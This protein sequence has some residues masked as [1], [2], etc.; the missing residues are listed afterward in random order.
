MHRLSLLIAVGDA[1]GRLDQAA[2]C[3]RG[4]ELLAFPVADCTDP[5][6]AQDVC[7]SIARAID[8]YVARGATERTD[9]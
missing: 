1:C 9:T 8:H 6:D 4:V 3:E 5:R 2:A 7:N